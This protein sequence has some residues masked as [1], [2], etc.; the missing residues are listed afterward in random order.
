VLGAAYLAGYYGGVFA[1]LEHI[2]QQ[3]R[4]DIVFEPVMQADQ[5]DRL[6]AGWNAAVSQVRV[7]DF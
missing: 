7:N 1:S 3:W 2:A 6:L 4:S 5:R